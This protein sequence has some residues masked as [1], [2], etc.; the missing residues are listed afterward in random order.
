[1]MA[2]KNSDHRK[3]AHT[4]IHT[5]RDRHICLYI[6]ADMMPCHGKL[7]LCVD[8]CIH[9][10][11]STFAETI[12]SNVLFDTFNQMRSF[13]ISPGPYYANLWHRNP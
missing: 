13:M 12:A 4:Q 2:G 7:K 5:Q 10:T 3:R 1:M 11:S 8:S 9:S 6:L